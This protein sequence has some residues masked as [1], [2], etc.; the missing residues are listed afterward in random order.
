MTENT[1][2]KPIFDFDEEHTYYQVTLPVHQE[3]LKKL[4]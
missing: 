2:P 1:S 4:V 3:V